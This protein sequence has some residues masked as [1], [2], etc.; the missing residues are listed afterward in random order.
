MYSEVVKLWVVRNYVV[1]KVALSY[2]DLTLLSFEW[3]WS[4]VIKSC[5]TSA[6]NSATSL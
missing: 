1:R 4:P 6:F 3:D 5:F 2:H